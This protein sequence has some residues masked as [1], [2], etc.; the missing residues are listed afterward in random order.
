MYKRHLNF[1]SIAARVTLFIYL[2]SV[3]IL[4]VIYQAV[5][6]F[7]MQFNWVTQLTYLA[8]FQSWVYTRYKYGIQFEDIKVKAELEQILATERWE[9]IDRVG[10]VLTLRPTFD[11]PLNLAINDRVTIEFQDQKIKLTGPVKYVT[12]LGRSI[13]NTPRDKMITL[14]SAGRAIAF[15]FFI[16]LPNIGARGFMWDITVLRHNLNARGNETVLPAETISANSAENINNGGLGIGSE[17]IIIYLHG[18]RNIVRTDTSLNTH[19]TVSEINHYYETGHFHLVDDWLYYTEHESLNRI[20]TDGTNDQVLY[21]LS[22]TGDLQLVGDTFY[23]INSTDD[24]N[25]YSLNLDGQNLTRVA[26][27]RASELSAYEDELLVSHLEGV[28]RISPDGSEHDL[29][30]D[31]PATDLVR[32]EGYY[33][34]KDDENRL[35]R[36]AD[37]PSAQTETVVNAPISYYTVTEEG[38]VYTLGQGTFSHPT[39]GLYVTDHEG[40]DPEQ[41]YPSDRIESLTKV[42]DSILFRASDNEGSMDM[43][44]Y[45]LESGEIDS[46]TY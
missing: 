12:A 37:H 39:S 27:V 31:E 6:G 45:D 36:Q 9:E 38:I 14:R 26:T 21:D 23:F 46:L 2:P 7:P 25:I 41:V 15:I 16:M 10:N 32:H 11:F 40:T 8:V 42:G 5:I 18:N 1:L 43:M 44:H 20:R 30:M 29:F 34:F 28:D 17:D 4:Q 33:Y 19:Q 24:F 22:H 35:Y 3:L 13:H